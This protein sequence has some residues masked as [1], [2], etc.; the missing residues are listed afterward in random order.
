MNYKHLTD[1][2]LLSIA[3]IDAETALEKE[4]YKRF[5]SLYNNWIGREEDHKWWVMEE[6]E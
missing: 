4:L 6:P 1:K 5:Q 3:F 2:E